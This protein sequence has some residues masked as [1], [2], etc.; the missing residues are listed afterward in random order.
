[1][2]IELANTI[3]VTGIFIAM[4]FSQVMSLC[5]KEK[6][7]Y[8]NSLFCDINTIL[9]AVNQEWIIM[10]VAWYTIVEKGVLIGID[11]LVIICV[12]FSTV[13]TIEY[14]LKEMS[15]IEPCESVND[16][17]EREG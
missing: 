3:S 1:M 5:N 16:I 8:K 4:L 15:S 9:L 7:N 17:I 2:S 14:R 10:D 6:N 11:I 12:I 13:S